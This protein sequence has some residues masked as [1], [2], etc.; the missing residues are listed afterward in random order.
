MPVSTEDPRWKAASR[1]WKVDR[2]AI[3]RKLRALNDPEVA[4]R[5]RAMQGGY[6]KYRYEVVPISEINVPA[7]WHPGR[8]GP[9]RERMV[10]GKPID[11]I[12]LSRSGGRYEIGDGIHRTNVA[13]D[14]GY[15]HVPAFVY[16][17]VDTPN[18]LE[19]PPAEKPR[20]PLG[21]WV[22]IPKPEGG[23]FYGWVEERLGARN[24]RGARRWQYSIALVKDGD[25]WPDFMDLWDVEFVPTDPPAWGEATKARCTP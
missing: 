8:P 1:T 5:S 3:A 9:L 7:A 18:E 17:W 25:D 22:K 24:D 10:E 21:A 4:A 11:P 2:A 12:R 13:R 23:R 14:L 15:T 20:L 16:E 19:K 6:D